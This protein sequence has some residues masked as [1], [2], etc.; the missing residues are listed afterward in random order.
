MPP[1]LTPCSLA[2]YLNLLTYEPLMCAAYRGM[3]QFD[4]GPGELAAERQRMQ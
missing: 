4:V 1:G 2:A 3:P